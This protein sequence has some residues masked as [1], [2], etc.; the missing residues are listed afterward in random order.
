MTNKQ[1]MTYS[2][3]NAHHQNGISERMIQEIQNMARTMII[4]EN[5]KCPKVV[6]SYLW[7]FDTDMQ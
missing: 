3:V 5:M 7:T 4:L 6:N 2:G 1:R